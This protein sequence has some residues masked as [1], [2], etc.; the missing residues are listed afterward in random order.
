[1][2]YSYY[3][4]IDQSKLP[5]NARYVDPYDHNIFLVTSKTESLDWFIEQIVN[6]RES[7]GF[8]SLFKTDLRQ[9]VLASLFESSTPDQRKQYFQV[10]TAPPTMSQLL[11]LSKTLAVEA[12][13]SNNVGAKQ[14][15]ER[16]AKCNDDC[17]F[18]SR[19]G[20]W[21]ESIKKAIVKVVGLDKLNKSEEEDKLGNCLMC[22][23]CALAPK[24]RFEIR[25]VLAGLPPEYIDRLIN[26]YG[27]KAFDK[28]WIL[29]DAI[30]NPRAREILQGKLANGKSKGADLLKAYLMNKEI[31]A[32]QPKATNG[33]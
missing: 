15:E 4:L 23:G 22:G 17:K 24:V 9:L 5:I 7:K 3:D 1:M 26:V 2:Q 25:S 12:V 29:Q 21:K 10:R 14:R 20:G 32:L 30:N 6:Y 16:A 8:P 19:A 27:I 31:K 28:C 11:T 18:H 13:H 33:R